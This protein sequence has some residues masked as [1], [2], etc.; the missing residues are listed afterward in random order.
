MIWLIPIAIAAIIGAGATVA[1]W[2]AI[3]TRLR[4]WLSENGLQKSQLAEAVVVLDKVV[5]RVRRVLR[6]RTRTYSMHTVELEDLKIDAIDDAGML[7]DL[8]RTGR[9]ERDVLGLLD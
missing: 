4:T 6:I 2:P 8:N 5:H 7:A 1:F 3:L 9:A